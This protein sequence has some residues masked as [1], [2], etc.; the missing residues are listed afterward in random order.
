MGAV[1]VLQPHVVG[2]LGRDSSRGRLPLGAAALRRPATPPSLQRPCG[3]AAWELPA[4]RHRGDR[5]RDAGRR[6]AGERSGGDRPFANAAVG[7]L[8]GVTLP[9]WIGETRALV[10]RNMGT[11]AGADDGVVSA[12]VGAHDGLPQE[13]EFEVERPQRRILQWRA[14]FIELASG[15]GI[16]DEFADVTEAERARAKDALVRIDE[17]TGLPNKEGAEDALGR[18]VARSLRTGV[19]FSVALFALDGAKSAQAAKNRSSRWPGSL[20]HGAALR[21]R[22]AAGCA[23]AARGAG[24]DAGGP[25]ARICPALPRTGARS[26]RAAGDGLGGHRA[27]RRRPEHPGVLRD[28]SLK[29]S[30]AKRLGGNRVA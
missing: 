13:M 14:R 19:P 3:G 18:E 28:A 29:L 26:G 22:R 24:G 15:T 23:A 7:R 5:R 1:A 2:R 11:S 30:E 25:R 20:F 21:L 16:L 17:S 9:R 12:V 27:V 10:L 6:A 8:L 4:R